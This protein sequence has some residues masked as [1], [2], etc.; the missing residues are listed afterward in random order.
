MTMQTEYHSANA[1][2]AYIDL[3]RILTDAQVEGLNGSAQLKTVNGKQ[4][5]YDNYRIGNQKNWTYIGEDSAELRDRLDRLADIK[6]AIKGRT[7]TQTRLVRILRA[8]GVLATD[9]VMGSIL[10]A[11]AKVG[12][13]RLGGTI[14]G[15]I[16]FRMY[17]AELGVRISSDDLMQ[18]GDLDIASFEKLSFALGDV[19]LE[20]LN[21]VLK[22]FRFEPLPSLSH[23][24]VWRWKQ[25]DSQTLVEFLTPA[26]GD[27]GLRDLPAL[28][29][30]A[31]ALNYLNFLIADPIKAVALYRSG[32][33]VQIPRPERYAIHKLIVATRR[34]EDPL[35]A[36][37]D[38]A[39]AAFLIRVLAQDRP[40][41][42]AE[43]WEMARGYGPR[44]R[45]RLDQS[46]ER[47]PETKA[48]LERLG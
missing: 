46:L 32:I 42:L 24:K 36:R 28:G 13:F 1:H 30:S 8:E 25:S 29:V 12:V 19:V 27:E 16:A 22:P 5:W 2:A 17:E 35:K 3:K 23:S 31:Q 34:R 21:E 33:L 44:W 10:A 45:E 9:A 40:V 20:P 48:L 14:V 37:K 43:A 15:T 47:M 6:Q 39:Q 4:Y 26:F 41:E 18:T 38:R 7:A 11:F